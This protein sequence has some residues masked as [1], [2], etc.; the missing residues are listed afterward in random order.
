M[1]YFKNVLQPNPGNCF[2]STTLTIQKSFCP[3]L[4]IFS[5]YAISF[6]PVPYICLLLAQFFNLLRNCWF[7]FV[8]DH[9]RSDESQHRLLLTYGIFWLKNLVLYV[10]LVK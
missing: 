10:K 4:L 9:C 3:L 8:T 6:F 7:F 5:V 1:F 2:V